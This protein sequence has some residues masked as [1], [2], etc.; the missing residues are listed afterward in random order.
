MHPAWAG[1]TTFPS[2]DIWADGGDQHMEGNAWA[3]G[4]PEVMR[5]GGRYRNCLK[6]GQRA[7]ARKGV[8]TFPQC[9]LFRGNTGYEGWA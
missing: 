5:N 9:T 8:C 7:Y 1:W 4:P 6:C 3:R 2:I